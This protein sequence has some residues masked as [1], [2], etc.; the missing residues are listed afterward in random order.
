MTY[1]SYKKYPSLYEQEIGAGINTEIVNITGLGISDEGVASEYTEANTSLTVTQ[2]YWYV[3]M[4]STNFGE[5]YN[6][7]KTNS[8]YW[9]AS[10]FAECNY[11]F[12][13][14]RL[15]FVKSTQVNGLNMFSTSGADFSSKNFS[16]RPVVTLTP[17]VQIENCT[18]DNSIDNMHK[19][20]Y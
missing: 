13:Y 15:Q 14:F 4:N 7:L 10:R 5:G 2:T 8:Y 11:P 17:S 18:G 6:V 16:L 12:A 1:T 19:I 20:K 3:D 9:V